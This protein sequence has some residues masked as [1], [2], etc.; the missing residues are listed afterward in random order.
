M[1]PANDLVPLALFIMGVM[2]L[3][4]EHQELSAPLRKHLAKT[5][6]FAAEIALR[7]GAKHLGHDIRLTIAVVLALCA[8]VKL[9]DIGQK[10]HPLG[11]RAFRLSAHNT[12][13]LPEDSELAG[14]KRVRAKHPTAFK[15]AF[16]PLKDDHIGR[17]DQKRLRVVV[18]ILAY[19]VEVLPDNRQ[20]HHFGLAAAGRHLGTVARELIIA[21]QVQIS[22]P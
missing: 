17:E 19:R 21:R 5:H 16:Q 12:V 1:Q 8:I 22:L 20:R 18:I 2:G 11:W 13:E 4:I 7:L 3:I 14:D 15:I 6:Q 9:L 10:K